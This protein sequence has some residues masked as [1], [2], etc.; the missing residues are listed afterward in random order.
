MPNAKKETAKPKKKATKA[1]KPTP[2]DVDV[3]ADNT[4]REMVQA[5]DELPTDVLRQ[6]LKNLEDIEEY[7]K[8][9]PECLKDNGGKK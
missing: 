4:L 9:H 1:K 8:K 3:G 7:N 5:L 2:S 6:L